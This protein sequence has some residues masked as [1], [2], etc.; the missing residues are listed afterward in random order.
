MSVTVGRV[1]A[2]PLLPLLAAA[3]VCDLA[4]LQC[5]ATGLMV[6]RMLLFRKAAMFPAEE[7]DVRQYLGTLRARD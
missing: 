2:I 1:A 5:G 7:I 6:P 4:G 3:H